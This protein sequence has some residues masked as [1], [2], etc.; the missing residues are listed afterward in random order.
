VP[1]DIHPFLAKLKQHYPIVAISNGNVGTEEIGLAKYFDYRFHAG[2][3]NKQ[4]PAND[5]FQLACNKLGIKT[6]ELLHVGD[7]GRAD[8]KGAI[9][10]G[11]QSAWLNCYDVGKPQTSLA[12]IELN[13]VTDLLKL[14]SQ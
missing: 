14:V 1:G 11:C 2:N 12:D 5:L 13:R 9:R 10:A 8:I 6:H 3:G 7:C 4:K